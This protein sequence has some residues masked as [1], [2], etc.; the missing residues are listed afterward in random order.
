MAS[1]KKYLPDYQFIEWNESNFDI[2][3]NKFVKQ[4]YE[5]KKYAFVSDV[6]RLYALY[7]MGRHLR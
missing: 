4:A 3:Y 7:T 1:W 5:Q 2:N 6:V